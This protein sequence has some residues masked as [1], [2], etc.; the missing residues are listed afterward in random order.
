M[1]VRDW[2]QLLIIPCALVVIG[3]LFTMQQDARQEKIEDQRAESER[4]LEAVMNLLRNGLL[5]RKTGDRR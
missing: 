4:K 5:L 1:T 3:F 2:L